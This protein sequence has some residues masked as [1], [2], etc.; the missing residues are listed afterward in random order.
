VN[1]V[2]KHA[3]GAAHILA[4]SCRERVP[5]ANVDR[6]L[7]E[8]ITFHIESRIDDLIAGGM[9]RADAEAMARRQFGNRLG[10]SE[11]SRDVKLL[12]PWLEHLI[13][14]VRHGLRSL[15]RAPIYDVRTLEE[16]I[17][18]VAVAACWIP[19]H[20]AAKVDP[21]LAIALRIASVPNIRITKVDTNGL[22]AN[23]Y[24][25]VLDARLPA[26]IVISG[27]DGGIESASWFGNPLAQRGYAVL[28]LA[29]FGMHTLPPSL[30]DVP[31][32]YF[33][34]AIDWLCTHS[35]VDPNRIAIIGGSR[36]GEAALLVADTY[37]EI[38]AVMANVPSHVMWSGIH[39]DTSTPRAAW[40]L[41]GTPLPFLRFQWAPGSTSFLDGF[42]HSLADEAAEAA[43]LIPVERINGPVLLMS[44]T[45][46]RVWPSTMMAD[47]VIERLRD[48]AFT[49]DY[50]HV[51]YENAGHVVLM[52]PW[53][54]APS[55]NQWPPVQRTLPSWR[56]QI[57]L[58]GTAEANQKARAD[59]WPRLLS[60]L[61][62][63]LA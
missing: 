9:T 20:R 60:F 8:E 56:G 30:V 17:T 1:Y 4:V 10:V 31:L 26:V 15:R 6:A 27:S 61:A 29:Y 24:E 34:T 37:R 12:L 2:L 32:E 52:P 36:G 11:A 39:P 51:H 62:S 23:F 45:D 46:D 50:E 57:D 33:K 42:V 41:G 44:G 3:R 63:S 22:V 40:S 25:P 53:A 54:V 48:H 18:V 16:R 55:G 19:A 35:A 59:S 21:I 5:A 7:D 58:G 13:R 38:R 14:D 47:R 28:A 49:F 43:A